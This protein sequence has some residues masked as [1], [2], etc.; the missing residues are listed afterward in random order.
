MVLRRCAYGAARTEVSR[1]I[2]TLVV[3]APCLMVS[4]VVVWVYCLGRGWGRVPW[5]LVRYFLRWE[6][7]R[8]IAAHRREVRSI[9]TTTDAAIV[10]QFA[11]RIVFAEIDSPA[12]RYFFNPL[13]WLYWAVARRLIVW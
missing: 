5:D 6:T 10:T 13:L 11:A 12:L 8:S 7:W 1:R 2:G 4:E 9:R 3:I